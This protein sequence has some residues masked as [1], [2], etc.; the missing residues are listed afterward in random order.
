M[1]VVSRDSTIHLAFEVDTSVKHFTDQQSTPDDLAQ[2]V[3]P[4]YHAEPAA[5]GGSDERT[6][7]ELPGALSPK[8][9]LGG[10]VF[11]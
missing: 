9:L 7:S 5:G 10:D 11:V 6:A 3:V 8:G 4:A 2:H 1:L